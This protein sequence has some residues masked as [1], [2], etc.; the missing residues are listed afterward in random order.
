METLRNQ[1]E[2][3]IKNNLPSHEVALERVS[4][5]FF[6]SISLH[7]L[8]ISNPAGFDHGIFFQAEKIKLKTNLLQWLRRRLAAS[9]QSKEKNDI[10]TIQIIKPEI[11]LSYKNQ[12]WNIPKIKQRKGILPF[13][14]IFV[15]EGKLKFEGDSEKIKHLKLEKLSG[16]LH[17]NLNASPLFQIS[18]ETKLNESFELKGEL[19]SPTACKI[20]LNGKNI[21]LENFKNPILN[22]PKIQLKGG[23]DIELLA[24]LKD[25]PSWIK[26][27]KGDFTAQAKLKDSRTLSFTS[28]QKTIPISLKTS[29]SIT[30]DKI[31][32]ESCELRGSSS[33]INLSG[34]ISSWNKSPQIQSKILA[35]CELRE[36]DGI[37]KYN[38][39]HQ[40]KLELT[41]DLSGNLENPDLSGSVSIKDGLIGSLPFSSEAK[42][43]YLSN[44]LQID[45]FKMHSEESWIKGKG[46]FSKNKVLWDI[47]VHHLPL[48]KFF[49]S[50][51]NKISGRLSGKLI[52]FGTME[53]PSLNGTCALK[54]LSIFSKKIGNL[55]GKI[56]LNKN[57]FRFNLNSSNLKNQIGIAGQIIEK[58]LKL[59]KFTI[60]LKGGE[61]LNS[62]LEIDLNSREIVGKVKAS[63]LPFSMF[64]NQIKSLSLLDGSLYLDSKLTGSL[65]NFKCEGSLKA[66]KLSSK[67]KEKGNS[68]IGNFNSK[69]VWDK[70]SFQLLDIIIGKTFKGSFQYWKKPK[71]KIKVEVLAYEGDPNILLNLMNIST[72]LS[73]KMSGKLSLTKIKEPKLE[74]QEMAWEGGGNFIIEN[75]NWS[76]TPFENLKINVLFDSQGL[77]V[78]EFEIKQKEGSFNL[79]AETMQNSKINPLTVQAILQNFKIADTHLAGNFEFI[80]NYLIENGQSLH[81]ILKSK[82][83]TFNRLE[84]GFLEIS[85]NFSRNILELEKVK[86]GNF[87]NG[88]CQILFN[89]PN[90][91]SPKIK[92]EWQSSMS[93]LREWFKVTHLEN[94]PFQGDLNLSGHLTGNLKKMIFFLIAKFSNLQ[95]SSV[96]IKEPKKELEI[97]NGNGTALFSEGEL[98]S[99]SL[100]LNSNQGGKLKVAGSLDLKSESLNLDSSFSQINADLFFRAFNWNVMD[101]KSDGALKITGNWNSPTIKGELR[102]GLGILGSISLDSWEIAG[103]FKEKELLLSRL[104][105]YGRKGSWRFSVLE[106]SWVRLSPEKGLGEY[107]L[108]ADFANIPLGPVFFVGDGVLEGSW[109][110][111]LDSETP[112]FMTMVKMNQCI[113]NQYEL[114]PFQ[115]NLEFKKNKLKFNPNP[116]SENQKKADLRGE[117]SFAKWPA[118]AFNQFEI[119]EANKKIFYLNGEV[120]LKKPA[121][122]MEGD[123]IDAAFLSGIFKSPILLSGKSNFKITGSHA[124]QKPSYQGNLSIQNGT[125]EE[126]PL[127]SLYTEFS[128]TGDQLSLTAFKAK[129]KKL[130]ELEA[131]GSL[132]IKTN[133]DVNSNQKINLKIKIRDSDLSIL[134]FLKTELIKNAKGS[135]SSDLSFSGVAQNP[136]INGNFKLSDGEFNSSYLQKKARDVNLNIQIQKNQCLIETAECS[137]GQGQLKAKG[138]LKTTL[139]DEI[140]WDDFDLTFETIGKHGLNIQVPEIPLVEE[141]L[142]IPSIPSRGAPL[143]SVR[144][145]GK[146]EK[147]RISGWIEL[148]ETLFSYAPSKKFKGELPWLENVEWDFKIKSSDQTLFQNEVA[149]AKIKGA[150]HLLGGKENFSVT[151]KM[152]STEGTISLYGAKFNLKEAELEILQPPS[153]TVEKGKLT[154]GETKNMVYLSLKAE[155]NSF[156]PS[157]QGGQN[158]PD[159]ITLSLERTALTKDFDSKKLFFRSAQDPTLNSERAAMRAG[160]GINLEG[161]KPEEKDLQIRQ[162]VARLLDAKLASP[163]ARAL[164]QRTKLIDKVEISQ[165][166]SSLRSQELRGEL[167]SSLDP[168]IGQSILLEKTFGTKLGLGYKATLDRIKDKADLIHQLQLRYPFYKG[169]W[170]YGTT[171]LDS[172][173]NL[174]RDPE[175]KGGIQTEFK[176]DPS[177]WF[178]K[179]SPAKR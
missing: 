1:I 67:I 142:G 92:G 162:G 17:T 34:V 47:G 138:K 32:I 125:L 75:G 172:K 103:V 113:A 26:N 45:A 77:K 90:Y 120:D 83:F 39:L 96:Q 31:E 56:H 147:P 107:R 148:K 6:N 131:Q 152:N 132:P 91:E 58:K 66:R 165:D 102:G 65:S 105:F 78:K 50:G 59:Q 14:K 117:I 23:L 110:K 163:L 28:F 95:T 5:N 106:D 143:F 43:S 81:G 177:N 36:L 122:T 136:E 134:N 128:S 51:A 121:F 123:Q 55:S 94:F 7:S 156:V 127:E 84:A 79:K 88:T 40:G 53:H 20:S 13:L 111:D 82:N 35:Q 100:R 54:N 150:F 57:K 72:E 140:L 61:K 86:W 171:E 37:F 52:G 130:F 9:G 112:V 18:G 146:K 98:N 133:N 151:G 19:E 24:N 139:E 145:L 104:N 76:K 169:I 44:T 175:R 60:A 116:I 12:S 38:A 80:G 46:T 157:Q 11:Q 141:K 27:K 25:F 33:Q 101:G 174:G 22:N 2:K 144:V 135:L 68:E 149:Y 63:A 89:Q 167:P 161:L 160:L 73:G 176:F 30:Q 119:F 48:E 41:C 158:I 118:V 166:V 168:L 159:T 21:Q 29:I 153:L 16:F 64:R 179:S 164:I 137:I 108:A 3:Q 126:F 99:L 124:L 173:E 8:K 154:V 115:L 62:D 93:Q 155:Q 71:T 170:F 70:E 114:E 69:L 42:I 15:T 129:T 178:K 85:L 10:A 74:E 4:T 87:I 97:F 49:A 109:K